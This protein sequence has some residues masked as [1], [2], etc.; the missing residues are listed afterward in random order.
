MEKDRT[1]SVELT[2][3]LRRGGGK[4]GGRERKGEGKE[5]RG[6]WTEKREGGRVGVNVLGHVLFTD[7]SN[8]SFSL[9]VWDQLY[10][11]PLQRVTEVIK[12]LQ[13]EHMM[14]HAMDLH[15]PPGKQ[16]PVQ[17]GSSHQ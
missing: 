1:Q 11:Q 17:N 3:C 14:S 9:C 16:C 4:D 6:K 2:Y 12:C 8:K 5:E 7:Q 15:I 13:Q 10:L